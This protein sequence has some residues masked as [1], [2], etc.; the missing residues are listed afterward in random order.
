MITSNIRFEYLDFDVRGHI[1]DYV[2]L[3]FD[4]LDNLDYQVL[5]IIIE[6]IENDIETSI[7]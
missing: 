1:P 4:N 2:L 6:K 7:I 5:I 3:H